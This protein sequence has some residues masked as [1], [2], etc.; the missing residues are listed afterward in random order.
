MLRVALIEYPRIII[1]TLKIMEIA[2]QRERE[3]L[4][5]G[6][7]FVG[8]IWKY[9][10]RK[11]RRIAHADAIAHRLKFEKMKLTFYIEQQ[12][13]RAR[14]QWFLSRTHHQL[15]RIKTQ[16]HTHLLRINSDQ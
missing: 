3:R 5:R 12:Q 10:L 7:D 9:V 11:S 4:A 2:E 14:V 15:F 1:K 6:W 16:T 8:T 13:H